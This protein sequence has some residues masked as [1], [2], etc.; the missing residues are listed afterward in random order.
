[1]SRAPTNVLF[2]Q[3]PWIS[4]ILSDIDAPLADIATLQNKALLAAV[5]ERALGAEFPG[6]IAP[7][8]EQLWFRHSTCAGDVTSHVLPNLVRN[9]GGNTGARPPRLL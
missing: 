5:P 7:D 1:M 2:K 9:N 3:Y 6:G 4:E 8:A